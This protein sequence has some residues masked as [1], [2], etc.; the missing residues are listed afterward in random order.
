MQSFVDHKTKPLV[1]FRKPKTIRDSHQF[2][3][4]T[5]QPVLEK[6]SEIQQIL[7][8]RWPLKIKTGFAQNVNIDKRVRQQWS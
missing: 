2:L 1:K 3:I 4:K 7:R 5:S 6:T 8:D